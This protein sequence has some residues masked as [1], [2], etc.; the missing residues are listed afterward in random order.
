[1]LDAMGGDHAP[2]AVLGGLR[3]SL[4]RGVVQPGEVVLT[5][6]AE[7]LRGELAAHGLPAGLTIVDA[8]DV[9]A[10]D[11]LP[12]D[13]LRRKPRNSI[14]IGTAL[15]K[16][17]RGDT[18]I[19]A[20]HTGVVVATA[21]VSLPRLEGIRRP[22]IA[23]TIQGEGGPFVVVDVGANPQPRA[24]DLLGYAIMG[25]AYFKDTFGKAQPRVG[26]MNIGSEDAKGNP[27]AREAAQLLR[28]APIEF[29]GNVEGVDVYAG[30]CDVVV[31]DGFTG[32]VMLKVSEGVAE[33]MLR[34]ISQLMREASVSS[35]KM[36]Q[37][38]DTLRRR[39][40][41]SEYGGALLL[42]VQGIITICHG[43]SREPAICNAIQFATRAVKSKVNQHIVAAAKGAC[44]S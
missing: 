5:G 15:L 31:C 25:A 44:S 42:G 3:M 18:F 1:V 22:G 24:S 10:G 6:P 13:A 26:L 17:G 34:T 37:V 8:P 9:L 27:L 40:D 16:D 12:V 20:G 38:L 19:S 36:D 28:D 29:V 33:Y 32:N 14:A 21:Q 7:T 4:E 39:V 35:H 11:E 30:R 2:G 43:R 23:V 41:Y